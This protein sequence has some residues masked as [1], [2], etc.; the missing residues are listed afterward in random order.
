MCVCVCVYMCVYHNFCIH[1]SIDENLD[2]F[3]VLAIV[4]NAAMNTVIHVSFWIKVFSEYIPSSGVAGS[5]SSFIPSFLRNLH[6]GC[7]NIHYFQQCKRV[8]FTLHPLQHLLFVNF[9]I[10]GHSDRYKVIPC[11]SFDLH[12]SNNMWCCDA[13]HIFKCLL[14]IC[15][16]PLDKY[17][18]R[19]SA[20]FLIGLF[21]FLILS[22]MYGLYILEINPLSVASFAIILPFW[23]LSFHLVFSLLCCTKTFEFNKVSFAYFYFYYSGRWVKEDLTAIY[24]K[25]C[26]IFSSRSFRASS[27][28]LMFLIHFEFLFVFGVMECSDFF[29]LHIAAQFSQHHLLKSL[30]FL[31]SI[32]LYSLSKINWL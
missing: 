9:F 7:F 22:C 20:H 11:C 6:S 19:Y 2:F 28:T 24:D 8:P 31:H 4:N 21:V 5:Y 12:F 26:S 1:L 18:F 30:T 10:D 15:M 32:L 23:G 17:L 25:E 3:H 16:S 29:L 27:L 14:F 13:E